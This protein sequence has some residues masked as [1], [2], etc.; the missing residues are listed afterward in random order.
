MSLSLLPGSVGDRGHFDE[1]VFAAP[2][3]KDSVCDEKGTER[4]GMGWVMNNMKDEEYEGWDEEY[5][6]YEG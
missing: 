1:F 3:S 6:G 4:Q 2:G 5:E